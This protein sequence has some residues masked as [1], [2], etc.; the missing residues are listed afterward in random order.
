MDAPAGRTPHP[1]W[2]IQQNHGNVPQGDVPEL[3]IPSGVP[4]AAKTTAVATDRVESLVRHDAS[5]KLSIPLY[6][7]L[8]TKA[9]QSERAGDQLGNKHG[10]LSE[11]VR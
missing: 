8:Y 10:F 7:A 2:R 4:M 3:S 1:A 11:I 6:D 5:D 9:L